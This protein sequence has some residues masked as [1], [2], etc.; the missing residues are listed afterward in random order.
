VQLLSDPDHGM[1][2]GHV[3]YMAKNPVEYGISKCVIW[4]FLPCLA[5]L[6]HHGI[7]IL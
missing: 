1:G 3:K 7:F 2:C 4:V 5:V 6:C